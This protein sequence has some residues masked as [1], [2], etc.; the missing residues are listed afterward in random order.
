MTGF[1]INDFMKAGINT[2][3]FLADWH[4]LNINDKIG[5]DWDRIKKVS[6][7]YTEAFKFFCLASTSCLE[8]TSTRKLKIT[9]RTLF[10]SQTHDTCKDNE[11]SYYNG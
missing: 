8:A 10:A 9:G 2:T 4:T 6:Q 3:V 11:I 5:G 1:K 7:Y